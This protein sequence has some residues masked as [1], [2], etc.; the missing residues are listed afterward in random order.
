MS[1]IETGVANPSLTVIIALA[2]ALRVLPCELMAEF[3][4][5]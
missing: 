2:L 1:R 4:G 5:F 3:E